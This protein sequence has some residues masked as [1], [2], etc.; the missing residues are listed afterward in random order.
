MVPICCN[1]TDEAW[2]RFLAPRYRWLDNCSKNN[3]TLAAPSGEKLKKLV[4]GIGEKKVFVDAL[5]QKLFC[6]KS[7]QRHFFVK[8][9]KNVKFEF[10][11]NLIDWIFIQLYSSFISTISISSKFTFV[12]KFAKPDK[13]ICDWR[14]VLTH[15]L[16]SSHRTIHKNENVPTQTVFPTADEGCRTYS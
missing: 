3:I 10:F 1:P 12:Q 13:N 15:T 2:V 5:L 11:G 14:V 9:V 6:L 16:F 4:R 8:I 7:A